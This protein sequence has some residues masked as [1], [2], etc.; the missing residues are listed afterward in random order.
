MGRNNKEQQGT[1][2]TA[3]NNKKQ[4]QKHPFRNARVC[5][6]QSPLT[7]DLSDAALDQ[8]VHQFP[9]VQF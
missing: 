1:T 7:E 2:K 5:V 9:F 3:K 6:P 4:Q 8:Y